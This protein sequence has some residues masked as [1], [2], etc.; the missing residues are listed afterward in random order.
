MPEKRITR[1]PLYHSK[2]FYAVCIWERVMAQRMNR[3]ENQSLIIN[4]ILNLK[5]HGKHGPFF[6]DI[7][8][9]AMEHF[10]A[11]S[12]AVIPSSKKGF[13]RLQELTGNSVFE[14]TLDVKPRKYHRQEDPFKLRDS[15]RTDLTRVYGRG[16]PGG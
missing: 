4:R 2:G 13:N 5:K 14:R 9:A 3:R 10:K 1:L 16:P 11:D 8:A 15:I 12:L 7:I 6:N